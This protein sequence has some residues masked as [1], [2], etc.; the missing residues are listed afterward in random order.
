MQCS[1]NK[2]LLDLLYMGLHINPITH[3]QETCRRKQVGLGVYRHSLSGQPADA[4]L[5]GGWTPSWNYDIITYKI[6][7]HIFLKNKF[8]PDTI[9]NEEPWAFSKSVTPT[10]TRRWTTRTITRRVAIWDQFLIQN[11]RKK[12][13]E[14]FLCKI[15]ARVSWVGCNV[16]YC[17]R[18][19]ECGMK[20]HRNAC[21]GLLIASRRTSWMTSVSRHWSSRRHAHIV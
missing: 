4:A 9:W 1:E 19:T 13:I 5:R 10:T 14:S 11:V 8:H 18:Y 6:A 17:M 12:A 7:M 3:A 15:L 21:I 20:H 2:R 16:S